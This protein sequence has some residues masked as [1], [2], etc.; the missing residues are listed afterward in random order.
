MSSISAQRENFK[1]KKADERKIQFT[2]PFVDFQNALDESIN[3]I[4]V[5]FAPRRTIS[6]AAHKATIKPKN[7]GG[8]YKFSVNKGI[9]EKGVIQRVDVFINEKNRY[10]F[11]AFYANDFYKDDFPQN[12]LSGKPITEDCKFLFS[13]FKNDLIEFKTKKTK[14]KESKS[15]LVYFKYI[16]SNGRIAYQ[17]HQK[18]EIERKITGSKKGFTDVLLSTGNGLEFLKKYQVSILGEYTQVTHEK[19][20]PLIKQMRQIKKS[21]NK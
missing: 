10:K 19:R 12:D 20:L 17:Q 6:G 9:A 3:N 2:P 1:Y 16:T 11:V 18:S 4:F 21:K 14:T 7:T 15:D 8:K 5:S 13:L